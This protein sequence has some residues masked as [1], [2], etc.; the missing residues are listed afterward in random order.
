LFDFV[1]GFSFFLS[2]DFL[3]VCFVHILYLVDWL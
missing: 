3:F 1:S 2:G